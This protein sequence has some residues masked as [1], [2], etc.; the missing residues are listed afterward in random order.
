MTSFLVITLSKGDL[1]MFWDT[2]IEECNCFPSFAVVGFVERV[3]AKNRGRA[4]F[5]TVSQSSYMSSILSLETTT[6]YHVV[7]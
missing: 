2:N 3:E 4:E 5:R 7:T 6:S 1:V